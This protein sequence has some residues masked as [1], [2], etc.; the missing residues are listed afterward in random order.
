MIPVFAQLFLFACPK[1]RLANF[2]ESGKHQNCESEEGYRSRTGD[3]MLKIS[4]RSPMLIVIS[5]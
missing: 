2:L 3:Y 5:K 1:I 4:D